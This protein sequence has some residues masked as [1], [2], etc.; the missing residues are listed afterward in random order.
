MSATTTVL[1]PVD[2]A[3]MGIFKKMTE[4]T[5][6]IAR[7]FEDKLSKGVAS[8]VKINYDI[9]ARV[10]EIA[11]GDESVYGQSAVKQLAEY[12]NVDGGEQ[13]LYNRMNFARAFEREYVVE[14]SQIPMA[15]GNYLTLY[16]WLQLMKIE[17]EDKREKMIDKTRKNNWSG[18]D[19]EK[20]IRSGA[21]GNT[22]HARQGGRKP[23][24]PTSPIAGLQK[25][26]EIGNKFFRWFDVAEKSTFDALDE[27]SAD[28]V[29]DKLL[30]KTEATLEMIT[31][32]AGAANE[33]KEKLAGNVERLK[34]VLEKKAEAAA[35]AY[36]E[37]GGEEDGEAEAD[38]KPKKKKAKGAKPS[39]N[40]VAKKKKKK[41]KPVAAE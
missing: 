32:A 24:S 10:A 9:G 31:K 6:A 14:Q 28:K 4:A 36:N 41:K 5:Q 38:N 20:E 30:E 21:A 35:E 16:H 2:K 17:D 23:K 29:D 11:D 37:E 13:G 27:I 40:G 22:K 15:N 25:T 1:A 26:F 3:R 7:D 19:L 39:E 34:D 33:M 12:L 18:N 8:Q